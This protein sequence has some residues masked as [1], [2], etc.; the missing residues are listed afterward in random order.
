[1]IWV[2]T[3]QILNRIPFQKSLKKLSNSLNLKDRI[4]AFLNGKRK[5]EGEREE[6][7]E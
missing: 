2:H 7:R 4:D 5:R 1:M 3:I 6:K